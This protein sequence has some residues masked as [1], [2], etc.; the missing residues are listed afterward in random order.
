MYLSRCE[1]NI[2]RRGARRLLGSPQVMHAAVLA[3]FPTVQQPTD[4]G[5]VL[6]RVDAGAVNPV[7]Y[8]VSPE[9]P[10]FT[11][12]VE[13]AGWPTQPHW[14]VVDYRSLLDNLEPSQVWQ[15]RL[16]ANPVRN[17]RSSQEGVRGKRYAHVTVAQQ[18]DWLAQRAEQLGVAFD[19]DVVAPADGNPSVGGGV[20]GAS[21]LSFR[22]EERKVLSFARKG[23]TV[24]V[25][26]VRFDGLLRITEPGRLRAALAD[27]VGP[28]K[29][30]GC[31]MLTLAP[32]P[33]SAQG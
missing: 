6:W 28:A 30:Y 12:I 5:R 26:R 2:A 8:V 24:T 19:V 29:G 33:P 14:G 22:V 3:S 10:D 16:A 21:P 25:R 4:A 17:A 18:T 23:R 31:G 20:E 7:L 9:A 15:F 1:L 13:Q 27:G 32:P 11:H